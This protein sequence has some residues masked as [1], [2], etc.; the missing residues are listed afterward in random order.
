MNKVPMREIR[1]RTQ[2]LQGKRAL[3]P[4]VRR[5]GHSPLRQGERSVLEE[6][7]GTRIW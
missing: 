1:D 6:R 4:G 5:A 3:T 2:G 7:V